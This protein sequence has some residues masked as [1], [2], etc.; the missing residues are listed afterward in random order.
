MASSK[1]IWPALVSKASQKIIQ[2]TLWR[3]VES[4]SQIATL[5]LVDSLEEQAVLEALIEASKPRLPVD[6]VDLHYL[7]ATPFRYPPLKWGSRFGSRFEPSL[8]YGSHQIKTVLAESAYYRFLF[9]QGM[10]IPPPAKHLLTQHE[11]FSAGYRCQPGLKLQ[12]APFSKWQD[13]ITHASNYE[14]SKA[15]GKIMREQNIEGFEFKSAR[16]PDQG[17]NVALYY[18]TTLVDKTPINTQRWVCET[19]YNKVS[20]SGEGR[21][22]SYPL[23]QFLSDGRLP[24]P[25]TT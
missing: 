16:C 17:V 20:F 7:L 4:Q 23:A 19:T 18:P 3:I 14:H 15:L 11:V 13:E 24:Q 2:G 5:E 1:P 10:Q 22:L 12:K 25:G 21:L 9:W 8:F 6:A